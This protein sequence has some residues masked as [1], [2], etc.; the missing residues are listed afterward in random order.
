MWSDLFAF[1]LGTHRQV[2]N[3][4]ATNVRVIHSPVGLFSLDNYKVGEESQGDP[5]LTKAQF[6]S[7]V[8]L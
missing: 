4:L 5:F 2:R 6:S 3:W 7:P 1:P 8:K